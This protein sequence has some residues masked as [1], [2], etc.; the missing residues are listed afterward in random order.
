M[1]LITKGSGVQAVYGPKAD[2]LKSDIQDLLDSGAIIPEVNMAKVADKPMPAKDFRHVTE[3]VLSVADGTVLQITGVKDQVFAAKMMGDG[4]AVEPT[5]GNIYAPVSGLV[6]SVFPTKHAF[7]LLTDSGLEV[8]VHVG[9]DT[10][11]L[12]GVP[13]SVKVTEGQRIEA[14]DLLVVADLAAIQSAE[15]ETTIVVAFTNTAEIQDVTLT[16]LGAQ[17][18]KTPVATVEL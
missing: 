4:F 8:L 5:N 14:G 9:L 6:T 16:S 2:I 15:R 12:N 10:V 7:G 11:A 17:P 13:F 18:A 3:E 1:G